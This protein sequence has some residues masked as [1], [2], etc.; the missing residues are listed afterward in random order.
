MLGLKFLETEANTP[1]SHRKGFSHSGL[2]F[3]HPISR[4]LVSPTRKSVFD[5]NG[6]VLINSKSQFHKIQKLYLNITYTIK[7]SIKL[8]YDI[9]GILAF[10][11]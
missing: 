9:I 7:M 11:S 2:I 10:A 5:K 3:Q 1:S 6:K 4:L 8:Q